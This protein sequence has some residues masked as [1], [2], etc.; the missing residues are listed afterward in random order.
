MKHIGPIRGRMG[1][2][3]VS[4]RPPSVIRPDGYRWLEPP[5]ERLKAKAEGSTRLTY[6]DTGLYE[7]WNTYR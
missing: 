3:M 4:V 2:R 7:D 5:D 1:Q 6:C